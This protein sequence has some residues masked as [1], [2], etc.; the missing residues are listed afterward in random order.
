[1]ML[2]SRKAVL[3]LLALVA[4][5]SSS[6]AGANFTNG[7][8]EGGNLTGWTLESGPAS[9]PDQFTSAGTGLTVYTPNGGEA[10]EVQTVGADPIVGINR[11]YGGNYSARIGDSV[12]WGTGVGYQYNT[13]RQSAVVGAEAGGGPGFLF[14]AWA[15]VLEISAHGG[16]ETPYFSVT[17]VKNGVTTIYDQSHYEDDGSVWTNAGNGW[18]Y[19]T[20][21]SATT[22]WRVESL[23]LAALGVNVGD[24]LTLIATARDCNPSAH[25]QYVY[26]DGF[27]AAAPTE[28]VP[29]PTSAYMGLGFLG[30]LGAI[31][32]AKRMRRRNELV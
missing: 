31:G 19:S 5:A 30:L 15:A 12:A 16:T 4:A 7:A 20:G 11:V 3:G 1:M 28:L 10:V 9:D 23:N 14:F 32:A 17:V 29:L 6:Y 13:I 27:G 25:A 8:F 18:K 24:T 21:N 26:L 22:G 2:S